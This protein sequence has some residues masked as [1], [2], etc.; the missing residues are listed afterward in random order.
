MTD[1]RRLQ[2]LRDADASRRRFLRSSLG[3]GAA[4]AVA[5]CG[6]GQTSPVAAKPGDDAGPGDASG[7][8]DSATA[9]ETL[10]ETSADAA[11]DAPADATPDCVDTDDNIEGPFF[12]PGSLARTDLVEPGMPGQK[13]ILTGVVRG[14]GC[15]VV[16]AGALLDFWQADAAGAYDPVKLRGHQSADK[17]GN[18]TLTTVIPGHYLNG[19][20]YRPAHVH[21]KVGGLTGF[22]L[23]TTQLYFDGDPYNSIDPFIKPRLIMK[24]SDAPDGTK[25]ARFDFV[26]RKA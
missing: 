16:L 19:S 23:L 13:I 14:E 15:G 17:D 10:A 9:A 7:G 5:A 21:V 4:V 1:D 11:L 2:Q 8:G 25:R 6:G 3:L 12:K 26:I 18:Y 22:A 20:Q 24:L